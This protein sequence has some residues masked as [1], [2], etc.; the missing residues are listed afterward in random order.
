MTWAR[1]TYRVHN[2]DGGTD[3]H[4]EVRGFSNGTFGVRYEA[5]I[6]FRVTHVNTGW[7]IGRTFFRRL[8]DAVAFCGEITP[9]TDWQMMTV[10][11]GMADR[12]RLTP[13][14]SAAA[15]RYDRSFVCISGEKVWVRDMEG[16]AA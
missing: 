4:D 8:R 11:S 9:L 10:E 13:L 3:S 12:E 16:H 5:G 1:T 7:L 14:I 6:G 2:V 15:R